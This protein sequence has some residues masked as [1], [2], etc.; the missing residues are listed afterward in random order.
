MPANITTQYEYAAL[1][2]SAFTGVTFIT[3]SSHGSSAMD[4]TVSTSEIITER[5]I[6]AAKDC[7]TPFVSPIPAAFAVITEKPP[8]QPN[9]NSRNMNVSGPVSLTPAT[10]A[11]VS[12]WPHIIASVST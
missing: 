11:A 2:T 4:A 10:C 6:C 5:Y 3:P 1:Y 9:A 12:T 7:L 8:V